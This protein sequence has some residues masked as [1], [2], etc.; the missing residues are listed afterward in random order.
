MPKKLTALFTLLSL[1]LV[2]YSQSRTSSRAAESNY[3]IAFASFAP[4]NMD[5][6]VADADGSNPKPLL[7]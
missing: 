1:G 6:F 4:L 7:F 3:T 2:V 5:L